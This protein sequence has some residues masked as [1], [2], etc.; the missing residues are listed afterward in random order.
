M[1]ES[2]KGISARRR[3]KDRI[4]TIAINAA[5]WATIALIVLILG[6][7]LIVALPLG[8]GAVLGTQEIFEIDSASTQVLS[9]LDGSLRALDLATD[10]YTIS[11]DELLLAFDSDAL[12]FYQLR[13]MRDI[14][15]VDSLAAFI[16]EVPLTEIDTSSLALDVDA[17]KAIAA[18]RSTDDSLVTLNFV[19]TE[20][21]WVLKSRLRRDARSSKTKSHLLVSSNNEELI[22]VSG[23]RFQRWRGLSLQ[24]AQ[25]EISRGGQLVG[26]TTTAEIA[27]LGPGD[28]T[29]LVTDTDAHLHRFDVSRRNFARLGEPMQLPFVPVWLLSEA[30]RRV[31][32]AIGSEG[33]V[34]V[35]QPASGEILLSGT[36]E[37]PS[38]NARF[39]ISDDANFLLRS[40]ERGLARWPIKNPYPESGWRSLWGLQWLAGY[41]SPSRVWHP[42]GEAIGVLSKFNLSPL[43]FGTFKAA[44]YGMLIAVPLALGAAIYTGY[45]L[46]S[47]RRNQL[48][49]ALEMLE[50]FPTVVLGFVAGVWLAPILGEYLAV[51][52]I[53]PVLLIGIPLFLAVL[54]QFLSHWFP[55]LSRR[56]QR[57]GLVSLAYAI[58]IVMLFTVAGNPAA[59]EQLN[60]VILSDLFGLQYDQRNAVLVGMVMGVAIMPTMF[61]IIEDAINAVP[62]A[63]SDGSLALGATRWQTLSRVVLPAASPAI[64]S[65]LLIG[66]ARG[67]GETMIVLLATGNMPIMDASP[68]T[69][70]RSLSAT[71]AIELPEAGTDT[72][73]FRLLFLA[74]LVLFGL[75]FILN[76]VAELFRQRLRYAYAH[77]NH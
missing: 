48:K 38:V 12:R 51:F 75:T 46:S 27:A 22:A 43:L 9:S 76:T 67:L 24:D 29:L 39:A 7:L 60:S 4:A 64:L 23:N 18:Y 47:R 45:F 11:S 28:E 63:L 52:L 10:G 56:P 49:P 40:D 55:G 19:K 34:L 41:D 3:S 36:I 53:L 26:I 5:G 25:P 16:A 35:I 62:R 32:F 31:S 71:I 72:T 14:E 70:L 57:I 33:Q 37:K 61:S 54:N 8:R 13:D 42:D 44:L 30:Y 59:L 77:G 21:D 50:A 65:A 58:S 20:G 1:L 69:G 2:M 6:Y 66:F 73:H 15:S 68:F 74:A 17:D